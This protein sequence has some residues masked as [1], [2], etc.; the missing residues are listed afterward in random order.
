MRAK[1]CLRPANV[2]GGALA[3]LL[4]IVGCQHATMEASAPVD[5]SDV[6]TMY[7]SQDGVEAPFVPEASPARRFHLSTRRIRHRHAGP[8]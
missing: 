5:A 1:A 8:R 4:M 2:M 6:T 7:V 3:A